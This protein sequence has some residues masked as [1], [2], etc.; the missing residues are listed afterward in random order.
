MA[1]LMLQMLITCAY[2]TTYSEGRLG[3]MKQFKKM[4]HRTE[5]EPHERPNATGKGV[6][7]TIQVG[8]YSIREIDTKNLMYK[9][10]C[11]VRVQWTDNRLTGQFNHSLIHSDNP[12]ELIWIPPIDIINSVSSSESLLYDLKGI[13]VTFIE[14]D[15]SIFYVERNQHLLT[16][17]MQLTRFPFDNPICNI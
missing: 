14:P 10:T 9:L 4:L 3:T 7:I 1:N 6:N 5:Y 11:A 2:L 16:C 17:A 13:G 15:G 12:R 8:I